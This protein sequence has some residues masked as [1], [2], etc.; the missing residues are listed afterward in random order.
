MFDRG[1][2]ERVATIVGV[3]IPVIVFIWYGAVT[4]DGLQNVRERVV[5]LEEHLAGLD[6]G[7]VL[8]AVVNEQVRVLAK[9][10]E[11]LRFHHHDEI[12]GRGHVD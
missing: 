4:V 11:W 5:I 3:S 12:E 2:L 7:Q 1:T 9:E 8:D 6:R 10:V